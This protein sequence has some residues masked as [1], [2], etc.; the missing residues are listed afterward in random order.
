MFDQLKTILVEDLQMRTE[1]VV[2]TAD[3]VEVGLDSL[4]VVELSDL[5]SKR[6]DVHVS[7]YELLELAT[8]GDIA[9]LVAERCRA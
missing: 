7:D 6:L 3:R 1:D 4:A 2:A 8:V 5:L 9:E